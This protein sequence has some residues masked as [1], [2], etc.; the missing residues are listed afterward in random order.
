MQDFNFDTVIAI[1][2]SILGIVAALFVAA[3]GLINFIF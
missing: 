2:I 1:L 3:N